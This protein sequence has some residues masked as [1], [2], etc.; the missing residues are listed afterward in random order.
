MDAFRIRDDLVDGFRSYIRSFVDV[1]DPRMR[2][3]RDGALDSGLFWPEPLLQLNPNFAAGG[4]VPGLVREGLLHAECERIF[5]ANKTESAPLGKPLRLYRHQVDAIRAAQKGRNYVL[6]TGTGSGKSL[7][8]ILPIVDRV[9]RSPGKRRIRAIVVYPMNALAN[10]QLGELRKFLEH[11]YPAGRPPVTFARYTGQ[12]SEEERE[13][14]KEAPPDILLTNYVMLELMLTRPTDREVVRAAEG[15]EFL[16][17]DELHTYRGRQGADVSM[18]IRRTRDRLRAT[19]L[20]CIGTSATLAGPGTLAAQRAEVAKVAS[21]IFGAPFESDDV[22]TETLERATS[23]APIPAATLRQRVSDPKPTLARYSD[24]VDDPLARWL[25]GEIGIVKDPESGRLVRAQPRPVRGEGSISARLAQA[26]GADAVACELAIRGLLLASYANNVRHPETYRPPF[27]FRL[28]QFLS[29]GWQMNASPEPEDVRHITMHEQ[30][31]VPGSDRSKVLLPVVFCFECG[32]DYFAVTRTGA[33]KGGA[34]YAGRELRDRG[35]EGEQAGYLYLSTADNLPQEGD[36]PLELLPEEWTEER[37]GKL[38]VTS[39]RRNDV[40]EPV[41]VDAAGRETASGV[42]AWFL[43][44]PFRLCLRCGVAYSAYGRSDA[45]RLSALN[46]ANRSTATTLISLLTVRMLRMAADLLEQARKLLSFTDNR[47]DAS[48]QAGHFNDFIQVG[49]VR[50][51]LF[52]ALSQAGADG[53]RYDRLAIAVFH[54]LELPFEHYAT[55]PGLR[56]GAA[57]ETKKAL[58]SVLEYLV[59]RDLKP[60]WRPRTASLEEAGLLHVD[61]LSFDEMCADASYWRGCNDVLERL[62]VADRASIARTVLDHLRHQLAIKVDCLTATG[63]EVLVHQSNQR[64]VEPWALDEDEKLVRS[65]VAILRARQSDE[66][67]E[68]LPITSRGLVGGYLRTHTAIRNLLGRAL[69]MQ[70][71]GD[72]L[73]ALFDRLKNAGLVEVVRE[74]RGAPAYQVPASVL[75]WRAGTGQAGLANP[76]KVPRLPEKGRRVNPF[77]V[78]YYRTMA[79]GTVGLEAR[80][81]TAQVPSEERELRE[82]RFQDADLPVL[83]CSPTMELGV[84]VAQL[85]VVHLRTVPPTPAN[86]AQRSGRAGRSGQPALVLSYCAYGSNHDRYFFQRPDRMVAGQVAPPRLDLGNE[87]LVRAHM[88]A[89]W[90]AETGANLKQSLRDVVSVASDNGK[91]PSLAIH[92]SILADLEN[93]AAMVRADVRCRAVLATIAADLRATRWYSDDWLPRLLQQCRRQFEEALERWRSLF[94]SA[95]SQRQTQYAIWNDHSR[96]DRE[97]QRARRLHDEAIRQNALLV[98]VKSAAQSDFYTYRYFAS[99]GFLPGY[100]FPR[101]PLSAFIPAAGRRRRNQDDYVARPRFLAITEFA[102]RAL[103]Y[104]EG[105]RYRIERVI[106]AANSDGHEQT[107]PTVEAKHCP[108]CGYFHPHRDGHG[109]DVCE[110]CQTNLAEVQAIT[111]LFQMQNVAARRVDRITSTEEER[112]R[113]G[114]DVLTGIRFAD[115]GNG[116]VCRTSTV[117]DG[118]EPLLLLTHGDA[119]TIRRVNRGLKR[120]SANTGPGFV[121]DLDNGRWGRESDEESDDQDPVGARTQR[122][123]PFV[124]DR[125]NCLTLKLPT[126]ATP[127]FRASLRAALKAAIQVE[128]QLE[129]MELAAEAIPGRDNERC[130]LFYEATEGGAG[131]LRRLLDEPDALPRVARKALELCH[132]DPA[133]GDDRRRAPHSKEDCEAACYDCLRSYGNQPEHDK[134]DRHLLREFLL[135]LARAKTAASPKPVARNAHLDALIARCESALERSFLQ[136]L[137]QH[138]LRLPSHAQRRVDAAKVRPDFLYEREQAVVYVD[139]PVHDFP[140]RQ[141]RDAAQ[142]EQLDALGVTVVRFHHEADWLAVVARYPDLFG[143]ASPHAS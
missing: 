52:R 12:E 67:A 6:T 48:L 115:H 72:L 98:D 13:R 111:A 47:Q 135:R 128:F 133:T 11:G 108:E 85:N 103:I 34:I 30:Q 95:D 127:E 45:S 16:V 140:D 93:P 43:P 83:Y 126:A 18:L 60:D 46:I 4:N 141:Q 116:P 136:F 17:F 40:P 89:I 94:R 66:L 49:L 84:D 56:F 86:Y 69:T 125:K 75:L 143:V 121:L 110:H 117:S 39:A 87:D 137:E 36:Y 22:I 96:P 105:A 50:A 59:Y 109:V 124:E 28:H 129:D 68:V 2:E 74:L 79:A 97:R 35:D 102:P 65:T 21:T 91:T 8:Y 113:Q 99:E 42:R 37:N 122:V 41:R 138:R 120:R 14:I 76:L 106:M 100:N 20:Q 77:F 118:D 131:V 90:L 26:C 27:A 3:V 9:L 139:G 63:Q 32:Q 15:L 61:Y 51:A 80:E 81:H 70:E 142:Q 55:E 104:H 19:N 92:D 132:F 29:P 57:E 5:Q 64:L 53:L 23:D 54:S 44:A 101:L 73:A 62:A 112:Q 134:L 119:A 38:K 107:D 10:S 33:G 130:T 114:Y 88:Q 31:F 123:I 24:F 1:R 25:E 71:V 58:R 82:K 78:E 7:S